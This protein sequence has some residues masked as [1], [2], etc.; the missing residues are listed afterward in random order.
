MERIW[1]IVAE[2][3]VEPGD[4]PSGLTKGFMNVT[5]WAESEDSARDKLEKYIERFNWRVI[6]IEDAR[7]VADGEKYV[8]EQM[9]DMIDRTRTNPN[10]IILGTFHGYKPI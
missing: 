3:L 4:M 10:A 5:T 8:D 7:P 2:I 9:Q 1:K 6:S